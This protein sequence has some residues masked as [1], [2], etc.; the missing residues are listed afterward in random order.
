MFCAQLEGA[1]LAGARRLEAQSQEL[2][3]L[4]VPLDTCF[5]M[6]IPWVAA[7]YPGISYSA[8]QAMRASARECWLVERCEH[9]AIAE[10]TRHALVQMFLN[11]PHFH[12]S[13]DRRNVSDTARGSQLRTRHQQRLKKPPRRFV[14]RLQP[15]SKQ[16][17]TQPRNSKSLRRPRRWCS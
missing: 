5:R 13:D 1:V 8:S 17:R 10:R 4:K 7:Q 16:R 14:P 12:T 11:R 9:D 2:D 15:Q 6:L 3:A